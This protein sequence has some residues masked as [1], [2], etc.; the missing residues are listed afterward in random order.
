MELAKS[1]EE[2]KESRDFLEGMKQLENEELEIMEIKDNS[3]L[4]I[5]SFIPISA[6][7]FL[8][9]ARRSS[10]HSLTEFWSALLH[11]LSSSFTMKF[12]ISLNFFCFIMRCISINS[13][14]ISIIPLGVPFSGA[15]RTLCTNL[16]M[17]RG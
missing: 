6:D 10:L 1:K 13:S 9:S 7:W 12:T 14:S 15:T 5:A 2:L 16:N 11:I 3:A 4:V 17:L 8:H